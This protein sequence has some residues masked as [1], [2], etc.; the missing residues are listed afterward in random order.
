MVS[1]NNDAELQKNIRDGD[2]KINRNINYRS[3]AESNR[4]GTVVH[5]ILFEAEHGSIPGII[6][7]IRDGN[8]RTE[9]NH[10]YFQ[11]SIWLLF[12]S[13]V[14]KSARK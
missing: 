4:S 1:D 3:R 6:R 14:Q 13:S 7:N 2:G 10:D 11:I 9:K 5:G 12:F 8:G